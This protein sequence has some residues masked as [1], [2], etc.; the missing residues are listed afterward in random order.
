MYQKLIVAGNLGADPEM[1]FLPSGVAVCNIRVASNNVYTKDGEK[2]TET[3]WIRWAIW[4]NQGENANK[5]LKKGSKV[6]MEGRLKPEINVYTKADGTMGAS[7]EATASS[8]VYL[9]SRGDVLDPQPDKEDSFEF[10]GDE[11]EIPF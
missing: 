6:L 3:T 4:G 5:Y 9:S 1:R 11:D 2:I 7:Y 10:T 8:V